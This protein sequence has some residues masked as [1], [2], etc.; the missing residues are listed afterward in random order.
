MS[1][2]YSIYFYFPIITSSINICVRL[3]VS[4]TNIIF[5]V[6][7]KGEERI[8]I[9]VGE[10]QEG[11]SSVK[12]KLPTASTATKQDKATKADLIRMKHLLL[13]DNTCD[14]T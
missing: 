11:I 7:C 5:S 10:M 3:H 14:A 1:C 9:D 6:Q 12:I 4:K 8:T 13:T 2:M